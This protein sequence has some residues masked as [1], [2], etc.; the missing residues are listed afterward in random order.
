MCVCFFVGECT[1]YSSRWPS[2]PY[3]LLTGGEFYSNHWISSRLGSVHGL[4]QKSNLITRSQMW[5]S[6]RELNKDI[7]ATHMISISMK[8]S[9]TG[10]M[11][12]D[13]VQPKHQLGM[14]RTYQWSYKISLSSLQ[15]LWIIKHK[16]PPLPLPHTHTEELLNSSWRGGQLDGSDRGRSRAYVYVGGPIRM[17]SIHLSEYSTYYCIHMIKPPPQSHKQGWWPVDGS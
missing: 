3:P 5:M 13:N 11:C 14:I 7:W 15:H 10:L 12:I 17:T 16:P 1:V 9:S 8:S 6:D 4:S 2:P